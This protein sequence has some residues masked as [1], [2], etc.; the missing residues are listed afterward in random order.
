MT[1]P[2]M[3]GSQLAEEL[4]KIAPDIPIILCTGFSKFI[5]D[6]KLKKS[7]IHY[8]CRKPISRA[9]FAKSIQTA[10]KDHPEIK[11]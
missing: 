11:E 8:F 5:S 2:H 6:A 9:E 1:M 4:K 7:G 10:M 3:N